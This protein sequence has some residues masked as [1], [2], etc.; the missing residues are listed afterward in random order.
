[1]LKSKPYLVHYFAEDR[2]VFFSHLEVCTSNTCPNLIFSF[3][4]KISFSF[5]EETED[6]VGKAKKKILHKQSC[7]GK[8]RCYSLRF[9]IYTKF[10]ASMLINN[11][12]NEAYISKIF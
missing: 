7:K 1:M 9:G 11:F 3:R 5:F 10:K 8:L 4:K 6:V 2:H 12:R